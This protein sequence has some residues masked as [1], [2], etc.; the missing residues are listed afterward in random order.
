[1]VEYKGASNLLELNSILSSTIMIRRLKKDVLKDLP[2]KIRSVIPIEITNR[3]EYNDVQKGFVEFLKKSRGTR[4]NYTWILARIEE[5]KQL[6]IK[7]KMK[8]ILEWIDNFLESGEKLVVFATHVETINTLMKQYPTIAVRY[9]GSVNEK[10]RHQN[11]KEFQNNPNI[12]LFIGMLDVEGKPAGVGLTLTA[13][14]VSLTVEFQWSPKVHD[15]AED[16]EHRIGQKECVYA[17]YM[18]APETIEEHIINVL[19]RKRKIIDMTTDGIIPDQNT[20]LEEL[21]KKYD[22]V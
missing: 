13:A 8:A 5:L 14:S 10:T 1:M 6:T 20:L 12:K 4:A 22:K 2:N 18:Y 21:I 7:G 9:D 15:Q 19:D 17:N 16:R 3:K 11:V